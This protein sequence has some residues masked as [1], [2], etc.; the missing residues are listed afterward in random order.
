VPP[1][2]ALTGCPIEKIAKLAGETLGNVRPY[3]TEAGAAPS[4]AAA[5]APAPGGTGKVYLPD[6][7]IQ[8][9]SDDRDLA[10]KAVQM[11]TTAAKQD[12]IKVKIVDE[13]GLIPLMIMLDEADE[14]SQ[15][16]ATSC[17]A[18]LGTNA[19]NTVKMA[20]E[21]V[22]PFLVAL[23]SSPNPEIQRLS[24]V[25]LTNLCRTPEATQVTAR[26][27]PPPA[28]R[29]GGPRGGAEDV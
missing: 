12:P 8:A 13:G 17:I 26:S 25:G 24:A 5:A 3:V 15:Q 22:V 23:L 10:R 2:T 16:C 7:I 18:R 28:G 6:I 29:V 19:A 20:E 27:A 11:L 1:L 14:L 9:G 21:G 4:A